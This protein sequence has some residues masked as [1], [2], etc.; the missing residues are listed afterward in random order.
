MWS[1][2]QCFWWFVR[3]WHLHLSIISGCVTVCDLYRLSK[4]EGITF[5]PNNGAQ[6]Q[7]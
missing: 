5:S 2:V 4:Y 3:L 7:S 1:L 6:L